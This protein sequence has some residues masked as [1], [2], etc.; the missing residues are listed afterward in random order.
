MA[1]WWCHDCEEVQSF[2]YK[3]ISG[4]M[5]CELYDDGTF[6]GDNEYDE[7]GEMMCNNCDGELEHCTTEEIE[8]YEAERD[9]GEYTPP[10][11][12]KPKNEFGTKSKG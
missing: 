5:N 12:P 7:E 11:P 4:Y 9:G 8:K 6:D 2:G 3:S 10:P 1:G